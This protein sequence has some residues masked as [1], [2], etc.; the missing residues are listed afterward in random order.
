MEF[1]RVW[2]SW[3]EI[4]V[5]IHDPF[6]FFL[7]FH[8]PFWFTLVLASFIDGPQNCHGIQGIIMC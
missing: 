7:A 2:R 8:D 5:R 1:I 4:R 6:A 3:I